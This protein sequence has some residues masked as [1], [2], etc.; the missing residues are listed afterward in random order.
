MDVEYH[1]PWQVH[2]LLMTLL[3]AICHRDPL[4]DNDVGLEFALT[5]TDE[6]RRQ[7][8]KDAGLSRSAS[9]ESSETEPD[10]HSPPPSLKG[11]SS[12]WASFP[13]ALFSKRTGKK[14]SQ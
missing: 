5:D 6:E 2:T 13:N 11:K 10:V 14:K 7:I 8:Y 9:E 3:K 12:V 1:L 4:I